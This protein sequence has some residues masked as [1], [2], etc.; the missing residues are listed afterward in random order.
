MARRKATVFVTAI[1]LAF[2]GAA[3]VKPYPGAKADSKMQK[4][5]FG[6]TQDGTPVDLYVLSNKQGAE[7]S[8]TN[9]GGTL[10]A[11]KVPDR[12]GK[13]GDV[14]L[15]YDKVEGYESG[16]A[17]FGA[18]VGRYGN[19]I[20]HAKFVLD[21][22]TYTL[23]KNDADN[24]LHGGFNKRAWTAKD[25][26]SAAGEALELTYLSKDGEEGYPGNLSVK[27]VYTLLAG[28]NAL[29]ID[30]SATT[31]KDTVLNLT[32]HSYFNLAGQGN[33]DVLKQEMTIH[34]SRFTPVDATLIPTGELREVRGTSF[35]FLKAF[36][37]GARIDQDEQQ[38]K[39]GK[40][41]DH[42]WV[43]DNKTPGSLFAAAEAY[44]SQSG[45]VMEVSTT[46]PGL[47]FYTG[48]FLD[49]TVQGKD[50]KVYVRRG[51][52][53]LET[54]HFPDSPNHPEFPTT[55]LKPGQQF[56]STTIYKFSTRK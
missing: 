45:R 42:N 31:D 53:C 35:D 34:A 47:Q 22:V 44:D 39:F 15:G 23:E 9:Y 19:R 8:I 56:H 10:V 41:Y 52:F 40:G 4:Q 30:Y 13:P 32:H 46:E 20:A 6:K 43:L 5:G 21:G 24:H 38:L 33:G 25:V 14:V 51:A 12:S 29:K 26:S 49:G 16:K 11:L 54:Q 28:Q 36:A 27:I 18:S 17:F 50:G 2:L 7:A 48:N 37:I 1:A 55:V 3:V